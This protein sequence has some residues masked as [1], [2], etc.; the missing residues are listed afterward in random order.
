MKMRRRVLQ[1]VGWLLEVVVGVV[2]VVVAALLF[3]V[4]IILEPL[5]DGVLDMWHAHR[6]APPSKTWEVWQEVAPK[7]G[8]GADL[9][10]THEG[11]ARS[12]LARMEVAADHDQ[13]QQY[14][15][16]L[17]RLVL[18]HAGKA[19]EASLKADSGGDWVAAEAAAR[20]A[21]TANEHASL[22]MEIWR[23][24][25]GG[26]RPDGGFICPCEAPHGPCKG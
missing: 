8:S 11:R 4:A 16:R 13:Q 25:C 18:L 3:V 19:C 1:V 22:A 5:V 7:P 24:V 6:S 12:F 26:R 17:A 23:G 21:A 14:V 9:A 2:A 20:S 10:S 15:A